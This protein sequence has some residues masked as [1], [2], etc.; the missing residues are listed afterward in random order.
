MFSLLESTSSKSTEVR[1][2]D[3]IKKKKTQ[4]SKTRKIDRVEQLGKERNIGNKRYD[5]GNRNWGIQKK[6]R[7]RARGRVRVREKE[8]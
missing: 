4:L 3:F 7:V 5:R 2:Q 6:E 1:A 8:R